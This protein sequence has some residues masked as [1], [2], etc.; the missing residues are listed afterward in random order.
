MG[1]ANNSMKQTQNPG[2][3]QMFSERK[4]TKQTIIII[5]L[6]NKNIVSYITIF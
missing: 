5:I 3:Y 6:T 4:F 1:A 2:F